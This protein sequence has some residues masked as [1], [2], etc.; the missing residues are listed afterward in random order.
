MT[1]AVAT[2]ILRSLVAIDTTSRDSNLLLIQ[3]VESY[4]S[5]HGVASERIGNQAGTKANLYARIGSGTGGTLLS[6]HTD[7]V[8]VD[9]QTWTT[10]PFQLHERDGK[11]YGRGSADMKGFIACCLSLVPEW[12][13]R[14]TQVHLCFTYDEE[15]GCLGV[16]SLIEFLTAR[17]ITPDIAVIGEPTGM[18]L[19]TGHKGILSFETTAYGVEGHS[20]APERGVSAI[21]LACELAA[22]LH[23][24]AEEYRGH[25]EGCDMFDPPCTTLHIGV[26]KGGT[27]RNIIPKE[28][29][30]LWEIRPADAAH[31]D[32]IQAR[33]STWIAEKNALLA[34]R[35]PDARIEHARRSNGTPLP[36]AR[37]L[38][39]L[40]RLMSALG[41]NR[42]EAVSFYTEA[43]LYHAA[44]F[45]AVVIGPGHIRHA[46][47]PDEYIEMSQME[48]CLAFLEKLTS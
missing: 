3:Y 29:S 46:H 5:R 24:L 19:V 17:G 38:P 8:P 47:A 32:D 10:P 22:F 23:T 2:D 18:Q 26:I 14:E 12:V 39:G 33:V 36:A 4:L 48:E 6:G 31:G 44:G 40:P 41:T 45:P 13:K 27:A 30:L 1:L 11:L 35:H 15:V 20:S 43:G 21:T 34:A 7:V 37:A 9:G 42:T 25:T 16:P 28:C